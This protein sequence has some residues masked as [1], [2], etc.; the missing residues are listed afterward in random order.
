MIA[1]LGYFLFGTLE[2]TNPAPLLLGMDVESRPLD[3]VV[4]R[5]TGCAPDVGAYEH[6]TP[7]TPAITGDVSFDH[8]VS[9]HD[10]AWC[11]LCWGGPGVPT[12]TT[13]RKKVTQELVPAACWLCDHDSD[14]GVDM[15]DFVIRQNAMGMVTPEASQ[16]CIDKLLK[17]R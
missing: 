5:S 16:V 4:F 8:V 13:L 14:G 12:W 3:T 11:N 7:Y 10:F 1:L 15:K 9:W 6:V 17:G 2:L